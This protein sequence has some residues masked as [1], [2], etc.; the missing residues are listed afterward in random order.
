MPGLVFRLERAGPGAV[1]NFA[2]IS[3]A[4]Q[5]MVGWPAQELQRE[6]RGI[7]SL[8][9]P[10][11]LNSYLNSQ[12]LALEGESDWY[13]QG[14]ILTAEQ[15]VLWADIRTTARPLGNGRVVWDGI[16][17]DI[18]ENK[19]AELALAIRGR[20]CANY[21]RTWKACVRKRRRVLPAKCTTSWVR[22]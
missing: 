14:R 7:R 15:E 2:Y 3:E 13:W 17:W 20:V 11:D 18:T 9:H 6:E 4:S 22:Y 8:V 12:T 19:L 10:Q 21:R 16:L 1:V 5:E